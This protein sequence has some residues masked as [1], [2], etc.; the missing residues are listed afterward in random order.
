MTPREAHETSPTVLLPA[1]SSRCRVQRH[2]ARRPPPTN[3]VFRDLRP[4]RNGTG[5]PPLLGPDQPPMAL[6]IDER[7]YLGH[8]RIA[9][10][11]RAGRRQPF[12]EHA[13][14]AK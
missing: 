9:P 14:I 12:R 5:M 1:L 3:P 11:C 6:A 4:G 13:L 10:E 2:R 8:Q 7:Q